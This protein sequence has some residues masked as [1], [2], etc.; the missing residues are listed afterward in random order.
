MAAFTYLFTLSAGSVLNESS[1]SFTNEKGA[2]LILPYEACREDTLYDG[3][4]KKHM[5]RYYRQWHTFA[6]TECHQDIE[7]CDLILVTGCDMTRQWATATY[8]RHNREMSSALGAQVAPVAE[9]DF[10]LSEGWR[11]TQAINTRLGPPHALH[12]QTRPDYE[13]LVNN[14]CIFL[15]GFYVKDRLR[16]SQVMNAG[17][18]Y[19][20]P[21]EEGAESVLADEDVTVEELVPSTQ[22]SP[23]NFIYLIDD[24]FGYRARL[25]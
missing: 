8:F 20:D 7:L 1:L 15:R 16:G 10:S 4:F 11:I 25:L 3:L 21:E 12:Q 6:V 24:N 17:A 14:Q 9:V 18:G 13:T 5:L 23:L 19:H 22:V 2:A